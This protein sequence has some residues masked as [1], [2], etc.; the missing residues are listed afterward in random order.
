MQPK[1]WQ[2]VTL[3]VKLESGY[4]EKDEDVPKEVTLK[5]LPDILRLW[6]HKG[7]DVGSWSKLAKEYDNWLR[8]RKTTPVS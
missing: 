4:D 1:K 7:E 8:Q 2:V 3:E 5:D 6:K